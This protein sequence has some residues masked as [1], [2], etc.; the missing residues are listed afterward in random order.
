MLVHEAMVE[1]EKAK[2]TTVVRVTAGSHSVRTDPNSNGIFQQPLHITV[3]QGT[4]QV[5]VDL[6][7][8]SGRVLA[9]LA[10][11]IMDHILKPKK[12][13]PETVYPMKQRSK[14]IRNPKMKLT[15]VVNSGSDPEMGFLSGAGIS[16]DV[17]I[18][19]RQQLRKAKQEGLNPSGEGLSEM[20]IL[21]QACAGPLEIFEGLGKTSSV[22]VAV[23]GPPTSRRYVLGI[24]DD[25]HSYDAKRHPFSEVDLLRI[26]SVQADPTR[27]HVFV[28]NY[29]DESR[30]PQTLTFRRMDRARDVWVE[31]LYLLVTKARDSVKKH[32][33]DKTQVEPPSKFRGTHTADKTKK[34]Y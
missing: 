10:L 28:V 30:V 33:R 31:I 15:L 18:L 24:W 22:Y 32:K 21:K 23:L 11:D 19:V 12:I 27:H 6:L 7:D 34:R 8:T 2:Q 9:T 29:F 20:Q 16:S 4:S 26:Q 1:S 25:K 17:D 14:G 3:E 5:V 13:S